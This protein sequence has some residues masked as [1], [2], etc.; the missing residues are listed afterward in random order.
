MVAKKKIHK[1]AVD[2]ESD[3]TLIGIAS[4]ENDYRLGW[5]INKFL[6]IDLKKGQDLILNH[7][8]HKIDIH[9]SMYHYKDEDND[10]D[11]HLI[12]NKS[13][14]GFLIPEMKNIDFILRI[15]GFPD[16]S[17]INELLIRLKKIDLVITAFLI[18][19]LIDRINKVFIF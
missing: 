13:E 7:P 16:T 5:A 3:F 8:K 4:H 2:F 9:Y 10:I 17:F 1:L 14:K 6:E 18:D 19:D 11:Y 12:S 15:S